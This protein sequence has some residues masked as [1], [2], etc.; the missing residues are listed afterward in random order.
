M[1]GKVGKVSTVELFDWE[2]PLKIF[3]GV[4][5]CKKILRRVLVGKSVI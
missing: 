4:D 1:I 2:S 5:V 3:I